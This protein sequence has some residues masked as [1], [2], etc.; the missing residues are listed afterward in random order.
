MKLARRQVLQMVLGVA[1]IPTMSGMGRTQ[2]AAS[3]FAAKLEALEVSPRPGRLQPSL[4]LVENYEKEFGLTLPADYRE[5]L[6]TFGGVSLN[7][8]YPFA[9]L[10]PFG[11]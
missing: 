7:A 8:T 11:Q 3:A 9:E 5:F 2:M 10:T 1:A 6:A 4:Q